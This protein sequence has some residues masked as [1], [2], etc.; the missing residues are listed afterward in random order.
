MRKNIITSIF[1]IATLSLSSCGGDSTNAILDG[2]DE[3]EENIESKVMNCSDVIDQADKLK[4]SDITIEAISWGNNT[5]TTGDVQMSLGDEKLEGMQQ[6]H[7]VV[8]FGEIAASTA[9]KI[10]K[11]SEVKIKATVGD[12]EY[13]AVK[14]INP[15]IIK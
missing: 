7:V 5:T 4:G 11:N 12:F 15:I 9:E 13:G 8:V 1:T 3:L 14:L 10:E 6:S 2:L